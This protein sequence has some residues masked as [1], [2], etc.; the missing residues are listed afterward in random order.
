MSAPPQ[1]KLSPQKHQL[2]GDERFPAAKDRQR[3]D[4]L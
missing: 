2:L 3:S 4:T 1:P